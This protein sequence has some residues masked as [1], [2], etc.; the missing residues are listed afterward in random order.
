VIRLRLL[1]SVELFGSDSTELRS[2]IAQPK[3]MA[4]LA[5]LAASTPVG[6]RRRE[7]LLAIF[8]PELDSG[9][10]RR[11]LS[12][13]LHVLRSE[14][15]EGVITSR[16]V[17]EVGI[18]RT[19]IS[20]DV[21]EFR[22]AIDRQ[23][24][25][26]AL[27]LY[28][29]ELLSGFLISG[30]PEFDQWLDRERSGLKSKAIDAAWHLS[31]AERDPKEAHRWARR[32]MELDPYSEEGIR[33][34]IKLLDSAGNRAEAIR[35]YEEFRARVVRD[36]ESEPSSETN[37]L[38]DSLRG[39]RPHDRRP[40]VAAESTS[41]SADF[42]PGAIELPEKRKRNYK[43]PLAA[44]F[45]LIVAVITALAFSNRKSSAGAA[46]EDQT[47]RIVIAEFDSPPG[48][49][50]LGRTISEA[51]R[52]DLSRS[53]LVKV[54]SDATLRDAL[55]LMQR[56]TM[57]RVTPD[58]AREIAERENLAGVLSGDVRRA[59]SGFILSAQ[60]VGADKGELIG[61]WRATARDSSELLG[62]ID[63]LSA[64]VRRDA[65]ESMRTIQRTSPLLRVST[66]SL[67]ALRKEA[68][69]I[70]AFWSED[71]RRSYTLL[72]EAIA[73]DSTFTDAY[74]MLSVLLFNSWTH[75]SRA[76]DAAIKA[77]QYR[78]RVR[79]A[80]RYNVLFSY[81]SVVKGDVPAA[82][83]AQR[84][85][86]ELDPQIVF[87][88]RYASLLTQMHRFRE[89]E[90][91]SLRGLQWQDNVFLYAWLA[92]ARFRSGKIDEARRTLAYALGKFPASGL[93]LE[94]RT[95]MT[96]GMGQYARADS[97][98]HSTTQNLALQASTDMLTGKVDEARSHLIDAE[99]AQERSG[100]FYLIVRTALNRAR[101][102]LEVAGDTSRALSIADSIQ[103]SAG[104][105]SLFP[106]ERPYA[107]LAHF[108]IR[109]GRID[110]ARAMLSSL[111]KNVPVDY[112]AHDMWLERRAKAMLRVAAGDASQVE[113]IKSISQ[114]DPQPMSALADVVWAYR[115]LGMNADAAKAARAYLDELNPR[116]TEDD[117]FNLKAMRTLVSQ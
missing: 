48:D 115:S 43:V 63:Q 79:D 4:L 106:N 49:T 110:R 44:A 64:F 84:N 87:W 2:I 83:D 28:R 21:D 18:D 98:A 3:P 45:V 12:Q 102:E 76:I 95:D 101:L 55:R 34:L 74:L 1:G 91:V 107:H 46:K 9:R 59:G 68:M 54:A 99:R 111:E 61:G 78:D 37:A 96:V 70:D 23:D 103:S 42:V 94:L 47:T 29:G 97:L 71:Y 116:R 114:T 82:I 26:T 11:A 6:F 53:N 32:A 31:S 56:D 93:L 41:P 25:K 16:G 50:A 89:A 66:T 113:E 73:E 40:P 36:L 90:L 15:D 60:L 112:R 85:A 108:Y 10:G 33:R 38:V 39:T 75:P 62:A 7:E 30:S 86:A 117:A 24:W 35:A 14:L 100:S 8:W 20:T 58:L 52:L 77:Y 17:E 51:L 88:G 27:D 57:L 72:N 80:E 109:A 105:L 81:Y 19:L 104:W 67:A 69:G 22:A 65:G 13:A 92:V 5:Y